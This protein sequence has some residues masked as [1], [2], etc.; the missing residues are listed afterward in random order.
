MTTP[1]FVALLRSV[2]VPQ[3]LALSRAFVDFLIEQTE[4][5]EPQTL[6]ESENRRGQ[7]IA[8]M[9]GSDIDLIAAIASVEQKLH[10][11]TDAVN[12]HTEILKSMD[13]QPNGQRQ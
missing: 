10:T 13:R 5:G 8:M 3:G 9:I 11:L 2:T 1:D 4:R 12:Q 6:E 7:T